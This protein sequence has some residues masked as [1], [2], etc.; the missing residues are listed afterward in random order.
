MKSFD[1]GDITV[2]QLQWLLS[3]S[4]HPITIE[5]LNH[6]IY[7][8]MFSL[9]TNEYTYKNENNVDIPS[10]IKN[11]I[12]T[13]N[14]VDKGD[15]TEKVALSE[16]LEMVILR[17]VTADILETVIELQNVCNDNSKNILFVL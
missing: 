11:I 6:D 8:P 5:H 13:E 2:D 16:G 9:I 10:D 12:D 14:G 1:N 15:V 3:I 7:R 17:G 4:Q